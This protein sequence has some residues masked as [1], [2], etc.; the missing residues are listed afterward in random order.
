MQETH[1]AVGD[2]VD[3]EM[4]RQKRYLDTK[5]HW[6]QFPKGNAV[7]VLFSEA[8]SGSFLEADDVLVRALFNL[9]INF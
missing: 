9:R 5:L 4:R 6:Q 7:Y 2:H 8:Q 1:D 3:G